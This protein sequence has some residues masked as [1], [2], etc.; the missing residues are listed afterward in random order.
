MGLVPDKGAVQELASASPDPAFSDSVCS[1]RS[2]IR[3]RA[4]CVVHS[5]GRFPDPRR[6]SAEVGGGKEGGHDP[7]PVPRV[8]QPVELTQ[9]TSWP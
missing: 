3:L 6:K 2:M 4:C 7:G 8:G 9:A 1:P 5:P